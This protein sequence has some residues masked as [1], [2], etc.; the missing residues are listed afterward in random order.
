MG[1]SGGFTYWRSDFSDIRKEVAWDEALENT[2]PPVWSPNFGLGIYYYSDYIYAGIGVPRLLEQNIRDNATGETEAKI[3]RQYNF[4]A[5]AA[6][7][8][9]GDN[10]IFK[11]S[12]L[13]KSMGNLTLGNVGN[14]TSV[15][16]PAQ[17]DVDV[18]LFFQRTLWIGTALRTSLSAAD[19]Y[20][21]NYDSVDFWSAI[22]LKNGLRIGGAYDLTL[23]KLKQISSGS[24]EIFL[25][26]EFNTKTKGAVN[27]RFF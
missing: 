3:Y 12:V 9:D 18:S 2:T 26:Y 5:G 1:L 14:N 16:V 10:L 11:P 25:G 24:F 21:N 6:I 22:Y 13:F 27:P 17:I 7:P 19:I 15:K 20:S 4:T 23:S 8:L